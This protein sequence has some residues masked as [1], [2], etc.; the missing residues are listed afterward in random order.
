M[1]TVLMTGG[2]VWL[3]LWDDRAIWIV[4]AALTSHQQVGS[5]FSAQAEVRHGKE[6]VQNFNTKCELRIPVQVQLDD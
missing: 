4:L 6:D 1:G 2:G 3:L 5:H